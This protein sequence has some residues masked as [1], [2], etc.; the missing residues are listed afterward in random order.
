MAAGWWVYML[1]CADGSLYT[2][3]ATDVARRVDEHNGLK[4]RGARYTRSRRPVALVYHERA[5]NRAAACRRE[6]GIKRMNR[7]QKLAL[8]AGASRMMRPMKKGIT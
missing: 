3:V 2:G 6:Y 1:R 5:R 8:I 4:P 7:R